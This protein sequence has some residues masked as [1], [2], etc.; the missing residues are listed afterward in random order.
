LLCLTAIYADGIKSKGC[1]D[2]DQECLNGIQPF[3]KACGQ[4]NPIQP[5]SH[6]FWQWVDPNFLVEKLKQGPA[7]LLTVSGQMPQP[8]A[9]R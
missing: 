6:A 5:V 8:I 3:K 7:S 2:I 9:G 4:L 1:I